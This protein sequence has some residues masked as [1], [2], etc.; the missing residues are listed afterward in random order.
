MACLWLVTSPA[1]SSELA[2]PQRKQVEVRVHW[3]ED[4]HRHCGVGKRGC[5][6]MVEDVCHVYVKPPRA[7]ADFDRME[8][9]GH[10]MMHCFGA[11]H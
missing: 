9:L 4:P 10:E 11:V 3:T 7:W 1:M 2:E 6:V 8:T 5:A